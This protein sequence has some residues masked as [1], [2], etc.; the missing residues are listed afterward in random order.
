MSHSHN[1]AHGEVLLWARLILSS[2][3]IVGTLLFLAPRTV[4]AGAYLL[5]GIIAAAVAIHALHG[6]FAGLEFLV[7]SAVAVYVCLVHQQ[8]EPLEGSQG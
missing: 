7:L 2:L 4:I 3:E 1:A 8:D 5:L 6:D